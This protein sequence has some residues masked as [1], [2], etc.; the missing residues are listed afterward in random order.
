LQIGFSRWQWH[1][2]KTQHA[3]IHISHKITQHAQTK[4]NIQSYI[5]NKGHFVKP[6]RTLI[7]SSQFTLSTLQ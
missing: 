3:K 4:H 6:R 1:Y 5:N 2:K 7:H